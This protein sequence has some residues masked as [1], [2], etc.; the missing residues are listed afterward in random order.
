[1]TAFVDTNVLLYAVSRRA[2]EQYKRAQTWKILDGGDLV[3]SLQVLQE[4]YAQTTRATRPKRLTED[5]ALAFLERWRR[6][7]VQETTLALLDRG[8][9]LQKR[10][11]FSFWDAMIV[12]AALAQGCGILWSEDMQHGRIVEGVEIRNPFR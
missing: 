5:E 1:M 6:F 8:F 9:E 10:H 3:F 12:A 7:P 11:R 4:F 2:D